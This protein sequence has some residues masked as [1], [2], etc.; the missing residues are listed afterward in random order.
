MYGALRDFYRN[1]IVLPPDTAALP[2]QDWK[3]ELNVKLG[4]YLWIGMI[5]HK[6]TLRG[7][8]K[9]GFVVDILK[10][11]TQPSPLPASLS[12]GS[13][14]FLTYLFPKQQEFVLRQNYEICK[15]FSGVYW[16]LTTIRLFWK[17][18][19]R[20]QTS[21]CLENLIYQSSKWWQLPFPFF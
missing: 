13:P 18:W 21:L 3:S 10:L 1:K 4:R 5:S 9:T 19:G 17:Q 6:I 7:A 12:L 8:H 11:H 14:Y 20:H 16:A 15:V 2:L